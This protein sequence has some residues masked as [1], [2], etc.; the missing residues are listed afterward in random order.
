[1]ADE[2]KETK[3]ETKA[4]K[5]DYLSKIGANFNLVNAEEI[6]GKTHAVAALKAFSSSGLH[7]MFE[8]SEL[9]S[10]LFGGFATPDDSGLKTAI[11]AALN[12]LEVK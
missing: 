10:P 2:T 11:N 8:E 12:N 3:T 9:R 5:T 1:M 6:F 7:G 4:A